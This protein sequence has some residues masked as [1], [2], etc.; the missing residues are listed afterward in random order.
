MSNSPRLFSYLHDL[1]FSMENE[2]ENERENDGES[3]S[4][5]NGGCGY[6]LSHIAQPEIMTTS[7][8]G[9]SCNTSLYDHLYIPGGLVYL[10]IY[11]EEHVEQKHTDNDVMEKGVIPNDR[12]DQLLDIVTVPASSLYLSKRHRNT[13]KNSPPNKKIH[14]SKKYKM[15][16]QKI[17]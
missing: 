2:R 5:M 14:H 11:S 1:E 15:K 3:S 6:A 4:E 13:K 8:L 7:F 17:D 9:G 16:K 12:F 10:P